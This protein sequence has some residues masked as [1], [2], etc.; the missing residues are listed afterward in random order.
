MRR[1]SANFVAFAV[2]IFAGSSTALAQN[3]IKVTDVS[4]HF[5]GTTG[6]VDASCSSSDATPLPDGVYTV[7]IE[8]I[9]ET[10]GG[11][12]NHASTTL[13]VTNGTGSF[14]NF[15]ADFPNLHQGDAG[16]MTILIHSPDQSKVGSRTVS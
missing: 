8:T 12:S 10:E 2:L 6:K 15:D 7:D 4:I 3:E 1:L 13:T 11:E 5:S 9:N 14:S 16:T